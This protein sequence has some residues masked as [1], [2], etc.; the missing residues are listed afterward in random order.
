MSRFSFGFPSPPPPAL[1]RRVQEV[2]SQFSLKII[3][4]VQTSWGPCELEPSSG[5]AGGRTAS[6]ILSVAFCA[7][8]E[9]KTAGGRGQSLDTLNEWAF[10][11]F[12][13]QDIVL[14]GGDVP[15]DTAG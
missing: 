10:L 1:P 15:F 14:R 5:T 3:V 9:K 4:H 12:F 13:L 11:S 8:G 2:S 7:V 6:W